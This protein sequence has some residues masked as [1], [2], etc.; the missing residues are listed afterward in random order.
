[1]KTRRRGMSRE[2]KK[3]ME[4]EKALPR[5]RERAGWFEGASA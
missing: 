5:F 3:G 4:K 1:M 2:L